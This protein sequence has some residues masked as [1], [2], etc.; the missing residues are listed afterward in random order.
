[1]RSAR[2]SFV[3]GMLAIPVFVGCGNGLASVEGTVTL[4]GQAVSGG[5][6]IY[7]TVSF[8][9]EAG[10]GA[11]AIARIDEHGHYSMR[12]GGKE[13]IEPGTYLVGIAVKKVTPPGTPDGMPQATLITP[14]RYASV[15]QSGLREVVEAGNNTIDFALSSKPS[16]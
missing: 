5:P 4:D 11:P 13:G 9:R 12:T 1:M 16:N 6:Q 2:A 8:S 7:G 10:G 14:P 3:I 15:T